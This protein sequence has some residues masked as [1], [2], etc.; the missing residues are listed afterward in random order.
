MDGDGGCELGPWSRLTKRND[1]Q[2]YPTDINRSN[3]LFEPFSPEPVEAEEQSAG[4]LKSLL[5]QR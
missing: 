3:V 1:P 5:R 2:P 4:G